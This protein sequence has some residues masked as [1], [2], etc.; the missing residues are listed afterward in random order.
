M[1]LLTSVVKDSKVPRGYLYHLFVLDFDREKLQWN[2]PPVGPLNAA[3]LYRADSV[4]PIPIPHRFNG[5]ESL[6]TES[7]TTSPH[8]CNQPNTS[9]SPFPPFLAPSLKRSGRDPASSPMCPATCP[10]SPPTRGISHWFR[11]CMSSARS[12]R[13]WRLLV[14]VRPDGSQAMRLMRL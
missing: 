12:S 10:S 7:Q 13:P 6:T 1:S 4:L 5:R 2:A 9:T 8:S 11:C 14:C 3:D